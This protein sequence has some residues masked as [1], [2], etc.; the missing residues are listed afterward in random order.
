M[1]P[2]PLINLVVI[3]AIVGLLL[4][5]LS[6]FSIDPFVT[7]VIRVII[8][9]VVSIWAIYLIAGLLGGS[10]PFPRLR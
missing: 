7:K 1:F 6:Q 5:A 3:L 9:V 4:W 10:P 8:I 2:A